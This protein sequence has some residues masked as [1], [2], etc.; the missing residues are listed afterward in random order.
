MRIRYAYKLDMGDGKAV[1]VTLNHI[2][3]EAEVQEA[4]ADKGCVSAAFHTRIK[5][6]YRINEAGEVVETGLAHKP[7]DAPAE[8][9]ASPKAPKAKKAKKAKKAE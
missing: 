1:F 5:T 2:K 4:Y 9:P 3:S 7:E 6:G 8:S